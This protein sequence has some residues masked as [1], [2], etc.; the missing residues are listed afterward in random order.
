MVIVHLVLQP[1]LCGISCRQILEMR[2]LSE[3]LSLF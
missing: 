3:I 2:R 1:Q